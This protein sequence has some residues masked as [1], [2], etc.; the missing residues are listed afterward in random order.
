MGRGSWRAETEGRKTRVVPDSKHGERK[1]ESKNDQERNLLDVG[2][3]E[4]LPSLA[5]GRDREA[6]RRNGLH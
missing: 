1:A 5:P 6:S 3:R 4:A 2:R